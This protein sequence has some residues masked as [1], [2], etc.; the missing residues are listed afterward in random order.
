MV[1]KF[2]FFLFLFILLLILLVSETIRVEKK[3][4]ALN[5]KTQR[6]GSSLNTLNSKIAALIK[7]VEHLTTGLELLS[8][9]SNSV[10]SKSNIYDIRTFQLP[11]LNNKEWGGKPVAYLEQTDNNIVLA[12][13]DGE[14]FSF[15]KKDIGSNS[16]DL[17]KIRTNIK[18]L[19]KEEKFYL[20]SV[21]SIKDLLILD[22]KIFF[23]YVKKIS[24]N[25]YNISIMSSEFNLNYLIF[26]D[27]FSYKECVNT[28]LLAH[29]GGRMVFFKN[30]KILL[31]IGDWTWAEMLLAQDK[32]SIFGK[33]ISID[34]KSKDYEIIAMGSR[35]AQGLYYDKNKNVIIHT[36]HG[37]IGGDEININFH[38]DNK[39]VENYGWPISSYGEHDDGK[40]RKEAPLHK[41][42]KDY[43]FI[44]PI[45]YYTPSIA[46][47][48]I[49]KI[50]ITFNKKFTNDFFV[51]ALGYKWQLD[52]GDQS[53]HHIRFNENFDQIIFE[54]IIPIGERIRDM[55][56]IKE[57]NTILMI[58][59]S[60]PAI[61]VLKIIN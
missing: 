39:I 45:K 11:F 52:E 1:P 42:H 22:N 13:G 23:S 6:Y 37:P 48:E 18:D 28:N 25:C 21:Y 49:A 19:I 59:E 46:I 29:S 30:G 17:N 27:F 50:P 38:P 24:N 7:R 4:L 34:L 54:D 51:G 32:N 35:N 40:F 26:S 3:I 47:S 5:Q 16:L 57:N 36:E 8:S 41:S 15:A 31:T 10:R 44:E 58:L 55:I 33:I 53:I 2:K 56:F 14:F 43:G 60:I 12:S 61:G 20:P 9:E